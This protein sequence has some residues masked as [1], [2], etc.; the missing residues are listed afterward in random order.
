MKQQASPAVHP[1][2]NTAGAQGMPVN[3]RVDRDDRLLQPDLGKTREPNHCYVGATLDNRFDIRSVNLA[4]RA[5]EFRLRNMRDMH[6]AFAFEAL[7]IVHLE[8]RLLEE[9]HD[10]LVTDWLV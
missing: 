5:A 8:A 9:A 3:C 10:V 7:Q 2:L 6:G 1:I 4:N